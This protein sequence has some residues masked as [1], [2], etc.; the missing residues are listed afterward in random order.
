MERLNLLTFTHANVRFNGAASTSTRPQTTPPGA[1]GQPLPDGW[2]NSTV[3]FNA[4]ASQRDLSAT[5][6]TLAS[7]N[8][9]GYSGPHWGINFNAGQESNHYVN[10]DGTYIGTTP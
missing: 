2:V 5:V 10:G 8:L 7:F 6:A 3:I 4:T 9:P 1:N